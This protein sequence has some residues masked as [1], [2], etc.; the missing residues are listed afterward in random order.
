MSQLVSRILLAIFLF[1]LAAVFYLIIFFVLDNN[2]RYSGNRDTVDF[3]IS[4]VIT[5]IGV[6]LYWGLI[7]R[8]TV[9][10]NGKRLGL[11]ATAALLCATC[12]AIVA[13][14]ISLVTR[15]GNGGFA[16]FVATVLAILLWLV[17]TVFLWRE[18]S[19]ERRA[20]VAGTGNAITCPNCGYNLT[21]LHESR[22]P[23]CGTRFTLDELLVAQSTAAADIA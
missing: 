1:P 5:W 15:G 12:G 13:G 9:K 16:M 4:G 18:T 20:R 3:L 17:A 21:G 2:Q 22:C 7:W 23:E 14:L 6:A 11:A 8:S 19:A 10:W